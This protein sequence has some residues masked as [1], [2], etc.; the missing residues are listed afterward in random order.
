MAIFGQI[1]PWVINGF[2]GSLKG[3]F[4]A[5]TKHL[6]HGKAVLL[7]GRRYLDVL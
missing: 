4:R 5:K 1:S 7:D 2:L 3:F 6:S